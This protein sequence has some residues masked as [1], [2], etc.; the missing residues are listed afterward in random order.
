MRKACQ[1][2]EAV[3]IRQMLSAMRSS[4]STPSLDGG[5]VGRTYREMLDSELADRMAEAGGMGIAN[6]LY[7]YL[8]EQGD[9]AKAPAPEPP[10]V[11]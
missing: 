9:A 7:R 2:F 3:L 4:A 1:E 6:V 5:S 10:P 11:P 8:V